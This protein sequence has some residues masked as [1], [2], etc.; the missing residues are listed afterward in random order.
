M[1]EEEVVPFET[2]VPLVAMVDR[3]RLVCPGLVQEPMG[4]IQ[5]LVLDS[6]DLQEHLDVVVLKSV[7]A[8]PPLDVVG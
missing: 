5:V 2:V 1:V 7:V 3:N 6:A 8:V 4:C